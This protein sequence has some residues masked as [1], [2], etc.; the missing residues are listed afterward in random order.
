MKTLRVQKVKNAPVHSPIERVE[1]WFKKQGWSPFEFQR[2]TWDA[3]LQ[4]A[5]GLI[6]APTGM[7]KTLAAWFGPILDTMKE[8]TSGDAAP[9]L[10]V[11]WITPLRALATD[12]YASLVLPLEAIDI[13]WT[14]GLRSGDTSS[15]QKKKMR[16]RM[17]TA[18]ITTPESLSLLLSYPDVRPQFE[19]LR[20]VIVDEWHELLGTKRGTQ[21]ELCLARLRALRPNLRVW[22]LSATLS[23]LDQALRTLTGPLSTTPRVL[24]RGEYPKKIECTTLIPEKMERFPWVGHLGLR[25]APEVARAME[26]KSTTLLFT[27]T[28]SQAELWFNALNLV[29]PEWSEHLALHHGSLDSKQRQDVENRLAAGELRGVVC[30]SSLDLGVDFSPV[31]QVI[32]IGSP[33]GVARFL[34]RAG[35]SGHQPGGV[36]KIL[37]VPTHAFELIEFTAAR[38]AIARGELEAREPLSKPLDVLAQHLVTLAHGGGFDADDM[39]KEVRNT[40]AFAALSDQEWQWV[41]DFVTRGGP[42]LRAYP[43]F[44]RVAWNGR[45]VEAPAERRLSHLHRMSIGTIS[46]DASMEVRFLKGKR[47]GTVEE[48]FLARLRRG[49]TFMF[50]GKVLELFQIQGMTAYVRKGTSKKAAVPRWM[51]GRMPLSSQLAQALQ[52]ILNDARGGIF[53]APELEAVRPTLELQRE[54]SEIPAL[55]EVL[56]ERSH[57]RDGHHVFIFPFAGRLV[58]E[59]L[60]PLLAHRLA[61]EKPITLTFT[62][63]DYGFELRSADPINISEQ[64]WLKIVSLEN[65]TDDLW[66]CMNASELARRQFRG[67]A[68]VAGLIIQGMPGTRKPLRYLQASSEMFYD[69]FSQ[70]DPQNLLL[71]QARR[72]VLEGQLEWKRLRATLQRL[73]DLRRVWKDLKR[74]SPFSFP[75]WAESIRGHLSTE[76]WSDRV[77]KMSHQLEKGA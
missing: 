1:T 32:Q 41:L 3:Y 47:I 15:Y 73:N 26:K 13:P 12:T 16:E 44:S 10:Q 33:K 76:E 43:Q 39:L 8:Q 72:E 60:A 36:S 50:G 6:H 69:V 23:N 48:S 67:I 62:A 9:P 35:R 22:G 68:R 58:H 45:R 20:C 21:T 27:N 28:R 30:T 56:I 55:G 14:V 18:L 40:E 2:S 31:D 7:G 42:S 52:K 57:S 70:H 29:K 63:N 24:V 74:F 77:R 49:E 5:S 17:P 61:R 37:G 11:L 75:L 19:T 65:L 25:M 53:A 46:S 66:A 4:G 54:L 64:N 51:G 38:E 71:E 34:Q 59:G